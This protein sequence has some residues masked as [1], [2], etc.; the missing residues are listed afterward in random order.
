M[1]YTIV[2]LLPK[3]YGLAF[4]RVRRERFFVFRSWLK[5]DHGRVLEFETRQDADAQIQRLMENALLG[6]A[7]LR[8]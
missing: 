4:Y 7:V 6:M 2:K 5:D 8:E 3:H 1:R